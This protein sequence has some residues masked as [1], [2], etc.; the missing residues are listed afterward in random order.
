MLKKLFSHQPGRAAPSLSENARRRVMVIG[1]DCAAPELVFDRWLDDLPNL[2]LIY[3]SGLHG[4]T[5]RDVERICQAVA[6]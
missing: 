3:Q 5:R 6:A 2:K 4:P 1:L